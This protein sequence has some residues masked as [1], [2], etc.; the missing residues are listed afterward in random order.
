MNERKNVPG[1]D[2]PGERELNDQ[3]DT[4]YPGQSSVPNLDGR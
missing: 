3:G 2:T 4:K 1:A